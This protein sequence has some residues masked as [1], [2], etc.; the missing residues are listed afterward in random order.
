VRKKY[1]L[2]IY[3]CSDCCDCCSYI[4]ASG[5]QG[6]VMA[7]IDAVSISPVWGINGSFPLFFLYG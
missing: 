2:F 1:L 7:V 4:K 5:S 6:S 3:D